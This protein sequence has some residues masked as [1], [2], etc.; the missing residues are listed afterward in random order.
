MVKKI[1]IIGSALV[2]TDVATNVIVISQP[3]KD[4]WYKEE[5]L[6]EIDR[7]SF[8][9]TNGIKGSSIYSK[10]FAPF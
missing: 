9:D 8:Y 2:V 7:V 5:D 1:E 3:T 4:T 6:S 10:A